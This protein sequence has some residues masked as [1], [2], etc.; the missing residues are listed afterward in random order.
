MVSD[1]AK[2]VLRYAA[3]HLS[4]RAAFR[5][6]PKQ[7]LVDFKGDLNLGGDL[8]VDEMDAILSVTDEEYSAIVRIGSALGDPLNAS[9]S[10]SSG[11]VI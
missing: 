11:T 9:T 7:A 5:N 1:N 6:N 4:F 3:L 10:P 8:T 2:L